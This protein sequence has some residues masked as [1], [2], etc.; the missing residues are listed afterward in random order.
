VLLVGYK[1]DL[2][3]V[4][5][6]TRSLRENM[7]IGRYSWFTRVCFQGRV[8]VGV[9]VAFSS[10]YRSRACHIPV[11]AQRLVNRKAWN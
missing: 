11:W 8:R 2:F 5:I 4:Y 7:T 1:E 6:G 10:P 3:Q 9:A